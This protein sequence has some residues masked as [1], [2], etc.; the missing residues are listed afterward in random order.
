[1]VRAKTQIWSPQSK[2]RLLYLAMLLQMKII[3]NNLTAR[4]LF[5]TKVALLIMIVVFDVISAADPFGANC[6]DALPG[7]GVYLSVYL[8]RV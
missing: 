6:L 8:P 4:N 7:R 3:I 2:L 5:V 1:M